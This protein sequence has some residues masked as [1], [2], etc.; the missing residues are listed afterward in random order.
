MVYIIQVC[1][2]LASRIRTDAS[3]SCSQVVWYI[4]LL[5]VQWKTPYD[6]QRNCPKHVEFYSKNKFEELVHLVG[7][8]IR[9]VS[10][11]RW[12]TNFLKILTA[13][14]F[15]IIFAIFHHIPDPLCTVHVSNPCWQLHRLGSD[16]FRTFKVFILSHPHA[17][18][19]Q[20]GRHLSLE[21]VPGHLSHRKYTVYRS[22]SVWN[23][24]GVE[25]SRI[26]VEVTNR[27]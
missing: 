22:G 24:T 9:I 15:D 12:K 26:S 18:K 16:L 3:W 25:E 5:C 27:I 7:F 21:E 14:R 6:G 19:T 23:S 2:Q 17:S 13:S 11:V 20:D 10:W 4:P 8:I 1:W